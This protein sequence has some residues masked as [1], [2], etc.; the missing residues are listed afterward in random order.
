MKIPRRS[1]TFPN[2]ARCRGYFP[3]MVKRGRVLQRAVLA[4]DSTSIRDRITHP[5]IVGAGFV[6]PQAWRAPIH[7]HRHARA[8]LMLH[9]PE[10]SCEI[11]LGTRRYTGKA[12]ETFFVPAGTRIAGITPVT[13]PGGYY[14]LVIEY[15]H[16]GDGLLMLSAAETTALFRRIRRMKVNLFPAGGSFERLFSELYDSLTARDDIGFIAFAPAVIGLLL[17]AVRSRGSAPAPGSSLV[18]RAKRHIDMLTRE[19]AIGMQELCD[20]I[21]VSAAT[22]R[23]IFKRETGVSLKQYH[24]AKKIEHAC[25]ML[26]DT[27]SVTDCAYHLGFASPAHF[28]SA[29]RRFTGAAPK[30]YARTANTRMKP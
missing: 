16:P 23:K 8:L 28:A 10:G 6:R 26:S 1:I 18:V 2:M 9:I 3:E 27:V 17:S 4:A 20:G 7:D 14:W 30:E 15:P 12:G 13:P 11:K 21:G 24:L 5:Y 25:A 29:F 19:R 22:I